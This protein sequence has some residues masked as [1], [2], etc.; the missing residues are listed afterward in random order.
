MRPRP[1]ENKRPMRLLVVDAVDHSRDSLATY[2]ELQDCFEVVA[3]SA[4]ANE[5]IRLTQQYRP[6]VI[7]MDVN[8][9]DMDGFTVTRRL[10]AL[11][12][13]PAVI[14]LTL[15]RHALDSLQAQEAGA[16]AC[17]DK[18]AGVDAIL[19]ALQALSRAK[20]NQS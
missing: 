5:V 7:I 13:P 20:E 8:L 11:D 1:K 17:V 16:V 14:L 4:R 6:D 12:T 10:Q 3:K 2:L 15:R 19:V 9:P 18:G